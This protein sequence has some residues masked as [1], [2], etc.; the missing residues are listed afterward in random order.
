MSP[1]RADDLQ[2]R[3]SSMSLTWIC[4]SLGP[5]AS[6]NLIETCSREQLRY[7]QMHPNAAMG[8]DTEKRYFEKECFSRLECL[9]FLLFYLYS[10]RVEKQ[11]FQVAYRQSFGRKLFVISLFLSDSLANSVSIILIFH[12][13]QLILLQLLFSKATS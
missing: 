7:L 9:C 2:F 3:W 12:C 5:K 8:G 13:T 10:E 11:F 1:L 6:F 4:S